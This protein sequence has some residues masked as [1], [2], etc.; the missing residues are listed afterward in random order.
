MN[1]KQLSKIYRLFIPQNTPLYLIQY[2]TASC[3]SK[4]KMCFY[5]QNI[6]S[7]NKDKELKLNEFEKI[8]KNF[9]KLLQL[10]LTGGEPFLREDIVE[11]CKIFVKHTDPLVVTI[12]T[13][14]LMPD[15]IS[16]MANNILKSCSNTFFRFSLSL[17]GIGS[18]HDE[19]RGIKGN[20]EKVLETYNNLDK[21]RNSF[22][23]F[24]ID[25]GTVISKYN[26]NDVEDIFIYVEKNLKI[27]NHYFALARGNT[28]FDIAKEVDL[29]NYEK[30]ISYKRK[31][32]KLAERRP[33]SRIFREVFELNTEILLEIVKQQRMVI[34]CVAGK[35]MIVI[36]EKG[37][38]YPCEI[39]ESRIGNIRNG[40]YDI[41][42]I[43]KTKS[44]NDILKYI[45][46]NKC[47]CTF[48]CAI[49]ASIVFNPSLYPKVFWN[50][51]KNGKKTVEAQ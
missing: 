9:N 4:C 12:P 51:L 25:M 20:F 10:S 6:D 18:K 27:D 37:D 33:F 35:N 39:L 44:C 42:Q 40:N 38:V 11:I 5:W 48:E 2:I 21:L 50:V 45:A 29:K 26:Q 3:N 15:K 49:N 47:F 1:L 46:E 32:M 16:N 13:N 31:Q 17:D 41:K 19:I 7:Q 30:M 24:N 8:A 43:I 23:N 22:K 36:N 14:A 28:R 34:P